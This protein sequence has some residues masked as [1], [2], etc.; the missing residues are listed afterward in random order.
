[1]LLIVETPTMSEIT[2]PDISRSTSQLPHSRY[3]FD[4]VVAEF[5]ASLPS[6]HELQNTNLDNYLGRGL[7]IQSSQILP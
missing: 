5:L 1:M 3:Y 6:L 7:S 4:D 2:S